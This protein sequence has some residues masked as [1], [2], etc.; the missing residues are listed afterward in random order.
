MGTWRH[1]AVIYNPYG[2]AT[3]APYPPWT[4]GGSI[5]IPWRHHGDITDPPWKHH[6]PTTE[7]P[8][9]RHR[10]IIGAPWRH[11]RLA[12]EAPYTRR[13]NHGSIAKTPLTLHDGNTQRNYLRDT[14]VVTHGGTIGTP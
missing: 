1:N 4:Q 14:I 9:G 5:G 8:W 13:K 11:H 6:G 2:P 3:N 7:A 12:T 10:D